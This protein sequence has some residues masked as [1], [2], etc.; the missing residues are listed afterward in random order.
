[1][2]PNLNDKNRYVVYHENLKF[3]LEHGLVLR[4]IHEA[5]LYTEKAYMKPFISICTEARKL[6]KE[7]FKRDIFKLAANGNFG[8]L[9]EMSE[10][11]LPSNYLT[12]TTLAT[13]RN[14]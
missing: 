13:G 1:M 6:A 9:M 7:D 8:K 2:V 5:V 14:F 4:K 10:T 12:T 3:Y 11:G